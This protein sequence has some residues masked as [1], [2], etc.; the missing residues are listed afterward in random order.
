[1]TGHIAMATETEGNRIDTAAG[2]EL[3]PRLLAKL[4]IEVP[5]YQ[6][7]E[8]IGFGGQATVY[9]ARE[10]TSGLTVAIKILHAGPYADP[11]SRERFRRETAA[12]KALN[13]ANIV[14]VI[15][16]GQTPAGLDFLVMNYVDGKPL[17]VLWKD[18]KLA[19]RIAPEPP[20]RLRLF[21]KICDVVQAAHRAGITHRDL[22]PS[23][24]LLDDRG[25][26]QVLD[27]GL[28]A[29]AFDALM[30]PGG[31]NVTVTGQFI[32]KLKYASPEQAR[33]NRDAI[34]IRTDVYALGVILYQILTNG[35]F[36]YEVVGNVV[37]VLNNIIHTQP[38]PPSA[39]LAAAT[40]PIGKPHPL[41]HG[42]PLVNETIE[43]VVLKALEKHPRDR[44]DSAGALAED[45]ERYLA[46]TPTTAKIKSSAARS[47][48]PARRLTP[49]AIFITALSAL[50]T[51]GILMNARTILN[52]V[53]LSALAISLGLGPAT[54]PAANPSAPDLTPRQQDL[55]MQLSDA[56]ANIQAINKALKITGYNVGLAYER[57]DS[58]QQGNDIMNRKGGG[59]VRWDEFY[60]KTA[61][62]Y[63][64]T[65]FWDDRMD[66]HRPK[67]FAFVYKANNDQIARAKDQIASLMQNQQALLDRRQKHEDDQSRLWAT[68]AWD[69]VEDR[70]T[71]FNPLCRFALKP[72][73]PQAAALRPLILFLRTAASVAHDGLNSIETDQSATFVSGS[74]RMAAAYTALEQSLADA[75]DPS[76]LKPGEVNDGQ[77]LK[78][79]CK[80]IAEQSK[81]IADDY[82][83][84]L[85][86]DKA[87]ED[88]SKLQFRGQLQSSLSSFATEFGKL[89][90]EITQTAAGWG[91][92]PD[93]AMPNADAVP[94]AVAV[95]PTVGVNPAVALTPSGGPQVATAAPQT[96]QS[97]VVSYASGK[98]ELIT[99]HTGVKFF[100]NRNYSLAQ[101]PPEMMGL[102]YTRRACADPSDVTLL[103]PAGATVYLI[104]DSDQGVNAH[105]DG[106]EALNQSLARSN[107]QRL[108]DLK[109]TSKT[110]TGG[111]IYRRSFATS[112]R[113]TIT[114]AG[115]CGVVVAAKDIAITNTDIPPTPTKL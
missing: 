36:P 74:Q 1:M 114:A 53:G 24:I 78:A 5:G 106:V 68:L 108:P 86:R 4:R 33:G 39:Q 8:E 115:R 109:P 90:D 80:E 42:P 47:V 112:A 111:A 107:W 61:K 7:L 19:A 101:I 10:L 83:N 25:E 20:A 54:Q 89:D 59:P 40:P 13:H 48:R 97:I 60:G 84:A 87:K 51:V 75:L 69:E 94:T 104:V 14:C 32:G 3:P 64:R 16:S 79:L 67:Q 41:R 35:A 58:S 15:E 12:L 77:A 105:L 17:D 2:P 37:D 28:A 91:L 85:D 82:S 102:S 99:L 45:V 71:E 57:I 43:A 22:S 100:N 46:G 21:K 34:D 6:L 96:S 26:P 18:R 62:D 88:D 49:R 29:T 44:Y 95:A 93:K 73:G 92:L 30:S 38:T 63:P 66:D 103:I 52:L 50:F 31:R 11:D 70:E 110:E 23:N 55:L 9:R 27:F 65:G 56:E 113:L 76:V 81:V 72:A 98:T